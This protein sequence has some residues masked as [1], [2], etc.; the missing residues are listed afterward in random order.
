MTLTENPLFHGGMINSSLQIS[1][2]KIPGKTWSINGRLESILKNWKRHL[3]ILETFE[4]GANKHSDFTKK[5]WTNTLEIQKVSGNKEKCP[6]CMLLIINRNQEN[7]TQLLKK[8]ISSSSTTSKDLKLTIKMLPKFPSTRK[9]QLQMKLKRLSIK[10]SELFSFL[11]ELDFIDLK[12][13][14]LLEKKTFTRILRDWSKLKKKLENQL[15][16]KN[17]RSMD[18]R[19][20]TL[21]HLILSG[22]SFRT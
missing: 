4:L 18:L 8:K 19:M 22:L 9:S 1:I 6:I 12:I 17:G 13:Q 5:L 21:I 7:I 16:L 2:E 3:I 15:K 20:R 14:M 11:M 10:M